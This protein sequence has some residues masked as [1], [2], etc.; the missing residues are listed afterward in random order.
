MAQ[1]NSGHYPKGRMAV[2]DGDHHLCFQKLYYTSSGMKK[3]MEEWMEDFKQS[4]GAYITIRPYYEEEDKNNKKT[5]IRLEIP[6]L[7]PKL[8][9]RPPATYTNIPTYQYDTRKNGSGH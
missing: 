2:Y 5:K 3:I 9:S 8:T 7:P 4:P 6:Q 1:V